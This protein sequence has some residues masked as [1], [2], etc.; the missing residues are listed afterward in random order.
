LCQLVL[1]ELDGLD[2]LDELDGLDGLDELDEL[3]GL[4]HS[5][6]AVELV[7]VQLFFAVLFDYAIL[8]LSASD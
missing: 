1:D 5:F 6:L 8:T 4:E 2:G 3:D 7:L